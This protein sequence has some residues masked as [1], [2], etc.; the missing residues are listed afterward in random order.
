MFDV[1]NVGLGARLAIGRGGRAL[2]CVGC[3]LGCG[4]LPCSGLSRSHH[5]AAVELVFQE[6]QQALARAAI[7]GLDLPRDGGGPGPADFQD[8]VARRACYASCQ[9]VCALL[10]HELMHPLTLP[11]GAYLCYCERKWGC[12]ARGPQTLHRRS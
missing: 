7:L 2:I 12:E 5:E 9:G 10:I 3:R 11:L 4:D 1:S 8:A 6:E